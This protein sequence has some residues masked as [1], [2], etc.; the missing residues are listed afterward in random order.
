MIFAL[1]ACVTADN[2]NQQYVAAAC[3]RYEECD[4]GTF[5]SLYDDQ[6]E[7]NDET[8]DVLDEFDDCQEFC[9]FDPDN[10]TS[11]LADMKTAD[12]EDVMSGD[13]SNDCDD[14]WDCDNNDYTECVLEQY[15]F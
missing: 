14:V 4:K 1:F 11:C 2:F 5:E 3:Q 13:F 9:D 15:G 10:A 8:L 7:C 12:C 6:A